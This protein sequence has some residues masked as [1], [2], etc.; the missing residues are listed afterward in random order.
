[1]KAVVLAGGK[2]TRLAPFTTV[3]PKPLMPIGDMPILEV[4]LRQMK[5]AGVDEVVLAI[6]HLG[7]LLRAFFGDGSQYGLRISYSIEERPLGTAGPLALIDGLDEPFLVVNG[8]TLTMLDLAEFSAF[9]HRSGAIATIALSQRLMNIDL[10]VVQVNE[11]G[12]VVGYVEKPKYEF[13][14]SMGIY[15]FEPRALKY[16]PRGEYFDFPTLV[17]R[18]LEAGEDV[19]GYRFE[20]YWKDLGRPEDYEQAVAD[21]ERMR[22][23][24]LGVPETMKV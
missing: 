10:G 12:A 9:H 8:D 23:D 11:D 13:Q 14:A 3:I 7:Q 20:G 5:R 22:E 4:M 15:L 16:I 2:G 17:L 19:A 21:F 24:F 18:L 1:M 6:G